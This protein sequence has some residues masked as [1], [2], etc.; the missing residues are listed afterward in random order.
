M[1]AF[2][3]CVLYFLEFSSISWNPCAGR[4]S[5]LGLCQDAGISASTHFLGKVN[6]RKY[7]YTKTKTNTQRQ[8]HAKSNIKSPGGKTFFC[9]Y[10]QQMLSKKDKHGLVVADGELDKEEEVFSRNL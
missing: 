3:N 1:K 9:I 8:T 2:W 7:K 10:L 6:L 5:E 4:K